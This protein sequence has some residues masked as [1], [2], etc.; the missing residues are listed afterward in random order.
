L[1]LRDLV[2][3]SSLMILEPSYF[4]VS[5]CKIE[6]IS[7]ILHLLIFSYYVGNTLGWFAILFTMQ[8]K[9]ITVSCAHLVFPLVDVGVKRDIFLSE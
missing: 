4:S 2:L 9:L 6:I 3:I 7:F 5:S 8:Y 1:E